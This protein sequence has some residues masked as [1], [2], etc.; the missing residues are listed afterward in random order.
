MNQGDCKHADEER[1]IVG[2]WVVDEISKAVEM[3]YSVVDVFEFWEYSVT[4][5]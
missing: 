4:R 2:T 1:C 3:G 5:F